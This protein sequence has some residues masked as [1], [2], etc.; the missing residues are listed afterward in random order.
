MLVEDRKVIYN[1]I[2][3]RIQEEYY[4]NCLIVIDDKDYEDDDEINEFFNSNSIDELIEIRE[5]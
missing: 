2:D 4:D 3:M 1:D 5:R